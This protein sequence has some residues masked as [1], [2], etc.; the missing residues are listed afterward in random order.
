MFQSAYAHMHSH[1]SHTQGIVLLNTSRGG[2]V[3]SQAIIQA[4]KSKHI[5]GIG[6]FISPSLLCV[7]VTRMREKEEGE[8]EMSLCYFPV[9]GGRVA[10]Y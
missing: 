1:T 4:L 5:G 3:D 7:C 2:L 8:E 9:S 6:K 10:S